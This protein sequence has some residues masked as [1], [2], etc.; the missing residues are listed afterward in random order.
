MLRRVD[1]AREIEN[2]L[3]TYAERID[4]GD[5]DGLA[6]LFTHGR[7]HGV[8]GGGPGAEFEGRDAVRALYGKTTRLHEDT[9]T[10]K[11]K[12]LTTN[13]I[14]EVDEEAGAATSR[15]NYVVFQATDA[16]PLQPIITG[17]YGDTF[18]R[19]DGQWWFDTRTMYVDQTGE[20]GHHLLF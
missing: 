4:R 7:I 9:G 10:P 3:Y 6:E 13:A 8:E 18:H 15:S 19:I 20:L 2:L 17:R 16:L 11:T 12:H 14:I 1:S 5:F